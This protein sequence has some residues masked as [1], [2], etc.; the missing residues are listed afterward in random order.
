MV[1]D[2]VLAKA[3]S[4]ER[5]LRRVREEFGADGAGLE[6]DYTRQDALILNLLRACETSIDLAMHRVRTRELGVPESSRDAFQRLVDAGNLP[7]ELAAS[8]MRMVGFR[9]IATHNYRELDVTIVRRIVND[10]LSDFQRFADLM[11]QCQD[12]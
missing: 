12:R 10:Q 6:A 11:V 2:I 7:T 8:M 9:N 5:C 3:E 4:I 1:D